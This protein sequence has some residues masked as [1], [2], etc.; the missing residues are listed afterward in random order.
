MI[1]CVVALG[2]AIGLYWAWD[3][4]SRGNKSVEEVVEA[5]ELENV[6]RTLK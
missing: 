4:P 2:T 5:V 1:G 6:M 3:P